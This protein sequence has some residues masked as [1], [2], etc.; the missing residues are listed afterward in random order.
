[1]GAAL[2]ELLLCLTRDSDLLNAA[3][4]RTGRE[5]RWFHMEKWWFYMEK[6]WFYIEQ[7]GFT[8]DNLGFIWKNVDVTWKNVFSS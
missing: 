4:K 8:W 5:T 6:W 1:L 7:G 3:L 2:P